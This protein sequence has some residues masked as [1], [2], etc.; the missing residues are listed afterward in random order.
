MKNTNNESIIGKELDVVNKALIFSSKTELPDHFKK[1]IKDQLDKLFI[2]PTTI[3]NN[4][5]NE[6][7][8]IS[9]N[10]MIGAHNYQPILNKRVIDIV[11]KSDDGLI[12]DLTRL[13]AEAASILPQKQA[14]PV[15]A[16][17]SALKVFGYDYNRGAVSKAVV[18]FDTAEK[19]ITSICDALTGA[20]D[21]IKDDLETMLKIGDDI[22]ESQF[23]VDRDIFF[24]EQLIEKLEGSQQM[25]LGNLAPAARENLIMSLQQDLLDLKSLEAINTQYLTT[26]EQTC[27][28]ARLRLKAV[29]RSCGLTLKVATVG[30]L[31]RGVLENNNRIQNACDACSEFAGQQLVENAKIF[32][33]QTTNLHKSMSQSFVSL[34][35]LREAHGIIMTTLNDSSTGLSEASKALK[36]ALVEVEQLRIPENHMSNHNTDHSSMDEYQVQHS[37]TSD[38]GIVANP[39]G[40][41][42]FLSDITRDK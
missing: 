40:T 35:K 19:T 2:D 15:R 3:D 34:E 8:S 13:K 32:Q 36:D 41:L 28:G 20:K 12:K 30:L 7:A 1:D 42:T 26:L 5:I 4:T 31:L 38:G 10:H 29:E 18:K 17:C 11:S 37:F 6:F 25:P 9:S 16:I 22:L 39:S 33:T 21:I 27:R 23:N 24:L 14:A